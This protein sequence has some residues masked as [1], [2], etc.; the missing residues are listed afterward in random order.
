MLEIKAMSTYISDTI[1]EYSIFYLCDD[2]LGASHFISL[3]DIGKTK[4]CSN[5]QSE[6]HLAAVI[7]RIYNNFHSGICVI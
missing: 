2:N 3:F 5:I 6:F 1:L 7:T 4:S